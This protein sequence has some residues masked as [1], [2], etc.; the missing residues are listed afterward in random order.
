MDEKD[1]DN[2]FDSVN[3]SSEFYFYLCVVLG[4]LIELSYLIGQ[5][6]ALHSEGMS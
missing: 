3:K 5:Y 2:R 4:L 1:H 6:R